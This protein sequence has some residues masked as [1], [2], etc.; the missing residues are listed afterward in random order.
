MTAT[1]SLKLSCCRPRCGGRRGITRCP[2]LTNGA[3]LGCPTHFTPAGRRREV[4][5]DEG[6]AGLYSLIP[7]L[8]PY[9]L[10]F[11]FPFSFVHLFNFFSLSISLKSVLQ[12]GETT[13]YCYFPFFCLI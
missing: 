4:V 13:T 7:L 8:L 11:S 10:F 2:W 9:P 6:A 3:S 1:R 12:S 5:L